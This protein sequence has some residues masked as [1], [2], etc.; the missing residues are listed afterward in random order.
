MDNSA[1]KSITAVAVIEGPDPTTGLFKAGV[2]SG[3]LTYLSATTP[4][5]TAAG[6]E[7]ALKTRLAELGY[8]ADLTFH[9]DIE[10]AR[11]DASRRRE[12]EVLLG[13]L[14]PL[15]A[16][17]L[18]SLLVDR[19]DVVD[20]LA[21]VTH[22]L[23]EASA[24]GPKDHAAPHHRPPADGRLACP[25]CDAAASE[26]RGFTAVADAAVCVEFAPD[27]QTRDTYSPEK[28]I[29]P[30]GYRGVECNSCGES[31]PDLTAADVYSLAHFRAAGTGGN[32]T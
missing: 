12:A 17:R 20:A 2:V 8:D 23:A 31:L 11:R 22:A 9:T 29:E 27:G 32:K 7:E 26:E 28:Q 4:C 21:T 25:V 24:G 19:P 14:S 3:L 30:R 1:R 18:G 5:A 15:T 10:S 6:A 16:H 13:H